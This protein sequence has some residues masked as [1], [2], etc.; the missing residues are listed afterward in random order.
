MLG[1]KCGSIWFRGSGARRGCIRAEMMPATKR[2]V[3]NEK[4]RFDCGLACG[5]IAGRCAGFNVSEPTRAVAWS[6]ERI[7]ADSSGADDGR[8][9]CRGNDGNIL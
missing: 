4:A 9:L 2:V 1:N 7:D 6:N 5:G 3:E 8:L